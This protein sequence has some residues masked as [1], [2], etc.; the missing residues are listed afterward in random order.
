MIETEDY[1]LEDSE[2]GSHRLWIHGPNQPLC[3]QTIEKRRDEGGDVEAQDPLAISRGGCQQRWE[4]RLK[5]VIVPEM[6]LG[7]VAGEV[8]KYCSCDVIPL[9]QTNGEIIRPETIMDG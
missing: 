2:I 1:F 3:G 7:Q 4:R 8:R 5:K 9:G 6:N